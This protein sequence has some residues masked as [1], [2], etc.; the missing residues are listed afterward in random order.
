MRRKDPKLEDFSFSIIFGGSFDT[1]D[2]ICTSA[3][4]RD[5]WVYSLR[6]LIEQ[7]GGDQLYSFLKQMW[8]RVDKNSDG[9]ININQLVVMLKS[10]N[11]NVNKKRIQKD[12]DTVSHHPPNPAFPTP[13]SRNC[14]H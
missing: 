8:A 14:D 10:V 4:E 9:K 13:T 7:G 6:Y 3:K 2:I 1:L 11:I 5:D 12:F